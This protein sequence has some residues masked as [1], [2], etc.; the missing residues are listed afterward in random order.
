MALRHTTAPQARETK[1]YAKMCK[2]TNTFS[3]AIKPAHV[4]VHKL[5]APWMTFAD[6]VG[7]TVE[8]KGLH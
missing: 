4:D 6:V 1:G 2:D 8:E 7:Y 3:D 5:F